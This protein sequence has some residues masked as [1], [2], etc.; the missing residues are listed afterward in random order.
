[1]NKLMHCLTMRG[2]RML[3]LNPVVVAKQFQYTIEIF[4]T[5]VLL[6]NAKPVGK[7]VYYLDTWGNRSDLCD[8]PCTYSGLIVDSFFF[9]NFYHI[10]SQTNICP[11]TPRNYRVLCSDSSILTV[12]RTAGAVVP[13]MQ[14]KNARYRREAR[15]NA[16]RTSSWISK[17][18]AISKI[19]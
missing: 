15:V 18:N 3:N 2:V 16:P 19:Y 7:I 12:V 6:T 1:M 8:P 4:L 11:E 14:G 13:A 17:H 5:E 9:V 10:W